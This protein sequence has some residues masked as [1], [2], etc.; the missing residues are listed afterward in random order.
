MKVNIFILWFINH[1]HFFYIWSVLY[2][3]NGC[4]IN[5]KCISN[6][7]NI[8]NKKSSTSYYWHIDLLLQL[9]PSLIYKVQLHQCA[10]NKYFI[11][12]PEFSM[13]THN[14]LALAILCDWLLIEPIHNVA[15]NQHLRWRLARSFE[16][17]PSMSYIN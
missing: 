5:K 12:P 11:P 7:L 13:C 10:C 15:I 14:S 9:L 6:T 1:E 8:K 17:S 16:P 2:L 4:C 3:F